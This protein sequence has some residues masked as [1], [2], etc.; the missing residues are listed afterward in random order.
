MKSF[1]R[2]FSIF[3]ILAL[4]L[5][6]LGA[7]SQEPAPTTAASQPPAESESFSGKGNWL[8]DS[9]GFEI[10]HLE[11]RPLTVGKLITGLLLLILLVW[12][13]RLFSRK[14]HG[15]LAR[16][17]MNASTAGATKTL[18]FYGLIVVA[19]MVTLEIIQVPLTVFT[20]LGGA[21]AIGVGFG[22]QNLLNNFISGL[23]LL[24][25]RPIRVGD[26][27]QIGDL[28]GTISTIGGRSTTVRTGT[29]I[30]IIIPNSSFLE[31]NVVNW[32][33]S[34]DNI[35]SKVVVGLAYGSPVEKVKE[36]LLEA[37]RGEPDVLESPNP[38]VLF[39]D[40]GDNSLVFEVHFWIQMRSQMD[41]MRAESNIRFR[42]NHLFNEAGLVIA[43][44]QRDLHLD[45]L[46]PLEIRMI[47]TQAETVKKKQ[48]RRLSTGLNKVE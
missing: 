16:M 10:I 44:P 5:V 43:F 4:L 41:R 35:R 6:N 23:I 15:L 38:L 32:T 31:Q 39:A 42:I 11:G 47:P 33:L 9:W 26:L 48:T 36:L 37:A 34:D 22:S 24:A 2:L 30:D 46:A 1:S 45:T 14:L 28:Y 27:I 7:F 20:L 18:L 21:V 3:W 8:L 19:T 40:F 29:N 12:I 25:E 13:S 17:G